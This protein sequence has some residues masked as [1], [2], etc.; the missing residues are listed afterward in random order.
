[1][2]IRVYRKADQQAVIDLWQACGLTVA[3]NDP[4]KDIARKLAISPELFFVAE[5]DGELIA[6]AMGGYEGHRGWIN[7]L[8][9]KPGMQGRGYGRELV[10]AIE[11]K[12]LSLGCPKINV[13]I[14]ESNVDVIEFYRRCGYKRDP[15]V[16]MGKRLIDDV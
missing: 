4:R 13:Q 6:A 12:L 16:S 5:A 11:R 1:M 8:A 7:Y 10:Q 15:V 2:N 14:R 9:V 3:W